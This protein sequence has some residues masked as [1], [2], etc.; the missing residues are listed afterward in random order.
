M[1]LVN[2]DDCGKKRSDQIGS[3]CPNCGS[4][5]ESNFQTNP[6]GEGI[7]CAFQLFWLLV[8]VIPVLLAMCGVF[9]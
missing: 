4:E 9:D 7:A 3:K 1:G 6:E 2:C 5:R 8:I